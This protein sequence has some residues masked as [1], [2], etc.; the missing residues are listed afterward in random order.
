MFAY[1]G[2]G[3]ILGVLLFVTIDVVQMGVHLLALEAILPAVLLFRYVLPFNFPE[4]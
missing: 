2:G 3:K 1:S 4:Y